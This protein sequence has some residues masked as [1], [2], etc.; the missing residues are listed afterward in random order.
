[1]KKTKIIITVL[2]YVIGFGLVTIAANWKVSVGII[3]IML[4]ND[5]ERIKF[6]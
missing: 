2:S 5:L 1:M 3:F 4:A 6:K